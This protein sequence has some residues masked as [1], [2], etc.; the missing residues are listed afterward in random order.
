MSVAARIALIGLPNCG[1]TALFNRLTGSHQKVANY[2]GVTV[3]RKEGQFT[4]TTGQDYRILDL[5]GTYSLKPTTLDEA[6]T[7]DIALGRFAGEQRP[8]LI[9]L[10]ADATHLPLSLR[11]ALEVKRLGLPMVLAL[12]MSDLAARRGFQVDRERLEQVLGIP[13]VE[14]VAV[15]AGGADSLI[16]AL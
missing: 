12:N 15:R 14:A 11:L 6:V 4:T 5:P 7:R 8:D 13:I 2:P 1:K 3:E 10:V 9:V 16:A